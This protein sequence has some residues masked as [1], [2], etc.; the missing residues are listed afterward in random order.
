MNM[1]KH[2]IIHTAAHHRNTYIFILAFVASL[3]GV[4]TSVINII[5]GNPPYDLALNT[6]GLILVATLYEI[7]FRNGHEAHAIYALLSYYCFIFTP[8]IWYLFDGMTTHTTYI[9]MALT[10][11]I[12]LFTDGRPQKLL[13]GSYLLSSIFYSIY[14]LTIRGL[15][16]H[17]TIV[18]LTTFYITTAV[19]IILMHQGNRINSN[20]S[21]RLNRLTFTDEMTRTY[22]NRYIFTIL[23]ELEQKGDTDYTIA[24]LD[25]DNFKQVNDTYG[26]LTGDQT[27]KTVCRRLRT[28]LRDSDILG[29]YGG[30]EFIIIM[31]HTTLQDATTAAERMRAAVAQDPEIE[32]ITLSIGL[33]SRSMCSS[34]KETLLLA[35]KALYE[36]KKTG[37]NRVCHCM[38]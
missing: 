18:E 9:F 13:L 20:M 14:D 32:T 21:Y 19:L 15:P 26:H 28:N 1:T 11:T 5:Q 7:P 36:A 29:R 6:G 10:L 24:I 23:E 35:D 34:S 2:P 27:L 31:K 37:K 30:D 38:L 22:N 3:A 33:C 16:R 12:T 17:S 25:L 8:A 4:A